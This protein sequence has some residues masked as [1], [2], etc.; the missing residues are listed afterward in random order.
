MSQPIHIQARIEARNARLQRLGF[1]SYPAYLRSTTWKRKRA[2][3]RASGRPM[4][5]ACGANRVQLHHLTYERIGDELLDDLQPLCAECHAMAHAL[6]RR[7]L[8]SLDLDGFALDPERAAAREQE[9]DEHEQ[10]RRDQRQRFHDLPLHVRLEKLNEAAQVEGS[11]IYRHMRSI[12][13]MIEKAEGKLDK[14]APRVERYARHAEGD[15]DR[16]DPDTLAAVLGQ[17]DVMPESSLRRDEACDESM[18]CECA[19]CAAVRDA[20]VRGGIRQ[21]RPLPRRAA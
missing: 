20:R 4:E 2:E 1:E 6:E 8:I 10:H 11:P 21:R 12:R 17:P 3:Y 7:Q 15:L 18:T 9:R 14:I 19:K 16:L 13:H 5:C